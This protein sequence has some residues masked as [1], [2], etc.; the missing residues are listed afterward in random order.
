MTSLLDKTIRAYIGLGVI[1]YAILFICWEN[2]ISWYNT[3]NVFTFATYAFLL[4]TSTNRPEEYY[5]SKRLAITVF[6]YSVIFVVLYMMMSDYYTGDTFLFSE[7]DARAYE[8]YSFTLLDL[9]VDKWTS[10]LEKRGW[11]FDDWGAPISQSLALHLLP[12]KLF[13]NFCYIMLNT[14]G[15]VLLFKIGRQIM[16]RSY[17]YIASLTY[18]I[19][20]YSIFFMGSYLKEEIMVFLLIATMYELYRYRETHRNKYLII[21][22][23]ISLLLLFFR[24]PVALFVWVAYGTLL[25]LGSKGKVKL[26]LMIIIGFVVVLLALGLIMDSA[27][28]YANDGDISESYYY[29]TYSQ[30][31]KIVLYIAALI[32]P[33]PQ[34]L[35][36]GDALTSK[37]IFGAGVLLKLLLAYPFWKGGILCLRTKA[38]SLYPIYVF[39]LLEML[40]LGLVLDSLELRKGMPHIPLFIL[41][42][43][44]YMS[45]FD[46][47]ADEQFQM[48]PYYKK[49]NLEIKIWVST[50]FFMTIVWNLFRA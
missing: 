18:A 32:G 8:K 25:L 3:L 13:V 6:M 14:A 27:L 49:V 29:M 36:T 23:L 33:F 34:L 2:S 15:S 24:I 47:D 46:E 35:Q 5:T 17:A 9:P 4:W 50:V 31:Q 16:M 38:E 22:G 42:A 1:L 37:S 43:F 45:R 40:A 30:S 11:G 26:L 41:A 12:F 48:S 10:F 7:S 39:C 20:S 21:G 19:A 44:W 28:R